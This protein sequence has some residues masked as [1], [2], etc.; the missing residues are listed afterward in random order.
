MA[1]IAWV[2]LAALL[3]VLILFAAGHV[4]EWLERHFPRA[5]W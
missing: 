5:R 3:T 2:V 4:F 1:T